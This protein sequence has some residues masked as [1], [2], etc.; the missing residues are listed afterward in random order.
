MIISAIVLSSM[1][2][3]VTDPQKRD[4]SATVSNWMSKAEAGH[5]MGIHQPMH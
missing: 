1:S 4:I 5:N 2:K 3:A